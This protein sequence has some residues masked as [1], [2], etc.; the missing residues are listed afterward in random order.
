M[1]FTTEVKRETIRK[2]TS[3]QCCHLAELAALV[4]V[5]GSLE[6]INKQLALKL[7]SQQAVVARKLYSLLQE[8][9]KFLTEIRVRKKMYLDQGNY[10]IINLP[11]Q[12]GVKELLLD[13]GLV[14]DSLQLK[15]DIKKRFKEKDCCRKAYLRG[16]FLAAG[17][18]ADPEK[19]YHLEFRLNSQNYVQE[20]KELFS[21]FELDI[22][23]RKRRNYYQLY[24]KKGDDIAIIL[25][26]LGAHSAL[27]QFENTRIH[28]EVRNRVNRLVN[29][30][31]ANLD[32]TLKAARKQLEN[33]ELIDK[34]K[35]LDK[36]PASLQEIAKIRREHP[37]ASLRELG[38]KL[39]LSKS[40]VNHRFRRLKKKANSLRESRKI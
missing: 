9:F 33:I 28:K 4:K 32:K 8:R 10:Y 23:Y 15:Y 11:P 19:E 25:N 30:E 35:G 7:V 18:I 17:S 3:N 21:Y 12:E 38:E 5:E 39:D 27:L 40:G 29:C 2:D 20:V 16:L 14:S 34:I 36:L 6:I 31:T 13:C 24:L 22:K 26:I 1:S 37:Y